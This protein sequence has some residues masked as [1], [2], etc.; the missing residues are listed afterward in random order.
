MNKIWI[1]ICLILSFMGCVSALDGI[2]QPWVDANPPSDTSVSQYSQYYSMTAGSVPG[3]HIIAPKQ[4]QIAGKVP[5]TV[6]FS[7]QQQAVPYTQYQSYDTYTG[8]NSLWIQGSTSWTQYATVPQGAFLSLLAT[9]STGG[10]GNLYEIHPDGRLLTNN[11]Y[12]F[13]GYNQIGFWADTIGQHVLLF[14]M[15]GQVSNAI[16]INVVSYQPPVY[17]QPVYSQPIY[18]SPIYYR[19]PYVFEPSIDF[20]HRPHIDNVSPRGH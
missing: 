2:G 14:V 7:Y 16:V 15:N 11:Y 8:G 9:S 1:S 19:Q 6:Y 3:T 18:V 17:Q 5:A 10:N 12:F 4:Y 13:P 20:N